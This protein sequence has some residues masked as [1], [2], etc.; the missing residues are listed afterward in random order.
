M[1][2]PEPARHLHEISDEERLAALEEFYDSQ[3]RHLREPEHIAALDGVRAAAA[4]RS[5]LGWTR[6]LRNKLNKEHEA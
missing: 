1:T 2:E 4:R 3:P 5:G 6:Q